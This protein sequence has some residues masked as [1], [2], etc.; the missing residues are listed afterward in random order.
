MIWRVFVTFALFT[1]PAFAG[2]ESG[3]DLL[4]KCQPDNADYCTGYVSG[5]ADAV[6]VLKDALPDLEICI[7]D[8]ATR[9]QLRD[10]YVGWLEENPNKRHFLAASTVL[11]SFLEAFPC[12]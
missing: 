10:V 1:S 11:E 2:F 12:D 4:R 3:N 7:P 8:K 9:S 6:A 5:M